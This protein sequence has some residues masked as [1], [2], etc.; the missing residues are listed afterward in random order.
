MSVEVTIGNMEKYSLDQ[1]REFLLKFNKDIPNSGWDKASYNDLI[2]FC[3]N[4]TL[5]YF[6]EH[7]PEQMFEF[8][9]RKLICPESWSKQDKAKFLGIKL[10]GI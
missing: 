10:E 9:E 8:M 7:Y 4:K 5:T 1:I 3:Y 2:A 6:K